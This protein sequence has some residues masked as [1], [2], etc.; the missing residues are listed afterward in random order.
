MG[1]SASA[2]LY[3]WDEVRLDQMRGSLTRRF[4]SSERMM[5]AQITF[6]KGDDV[7]RHSHDN[8][9][10]TYVLSGTLKFWFG[11]GDD[12]VEMVVDEG[13]LVIIPGGLPHRAIALSDTFELDIFC[14]PRADWI[15]G[16]DA[17][18]RR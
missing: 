3:K 11:E 16:S 5:I 14:P 8:E 10:L 1:Q 4:V 17:Y 15:D 2:L 9:Q 6:K 13:S 18:L 7:P 12:E